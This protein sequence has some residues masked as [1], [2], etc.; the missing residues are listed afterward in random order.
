MGSVTSPLN[1]GIA[2]LL[3]SFTN[4]GNSALSSELTSPTVESALQK[5]PPAEIVQLSNQSFQMQEMDALFG[6]PGASTA[7]ASPLSS[8]F[9]STANAS[10]SSILQSLDASLL[11]ATNST[12]ST[13]ATANQ[14]SSMASQLANYQ[15]ALDA[16]QVQSLFAS[17]VNTGSSALV[18]VLA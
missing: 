3:E 7:P 18:N 11:T 8:L 12:T 6:N 14:A 1:P 2:T 13:D 4:S 10:P 16:Q 17:D 5:A 9:P 15:S